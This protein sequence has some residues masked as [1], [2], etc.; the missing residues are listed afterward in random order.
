[1]NNF[2]IVKTSKFNLACGV[3]QSGQN[4]YLGFKWELRT[5]P[6]ELLQLII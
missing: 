3:P 1:M 6:N 5:L 2:S 4:A